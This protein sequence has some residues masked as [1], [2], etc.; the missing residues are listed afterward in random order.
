MTLPNTG[1]V[2]GL[3]DATMQLIDLLVY[4]AGMHFPLLESTKGVSLE[5]QRPGIP[6]NAG[7]SWHSSSATSGYGTPTKINSQYMTPKQSDTQILVEPGTISPNLDGIDDYTTIVINGTGEDAF[8]SIYIFDISGNFI[9]T[10][11]SNALC[12]NR[13]ENYWDGTAENGSCCKRGVYVLMAIIGRLDGSR[14]VK[15]IPVVLVYE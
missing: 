6:S 5:K 3:F 14:Q 7:K 9:K 4:D 2:I 12:G 1:G 10:I 15:K 13:Y 8:V 11:E